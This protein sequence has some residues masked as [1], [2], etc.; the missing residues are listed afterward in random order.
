MRRK[1]VNTINKDAHRGKSAV[2]RYKQ[3]VTRFRNSKTSFRVVKESPV[4]PKIDKDK[5]NEAVE[6]ALLLVP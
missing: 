4:S 2:Y 6:K 5:I 1:A 3:L